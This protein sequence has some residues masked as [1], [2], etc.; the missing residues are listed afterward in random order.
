M[1]LLKYLSLSIL[2]LLFVV[3]AKATTSCDTHAAANS[4]ANYPTE[5]W[6]QNM[7][8][9]GDPNWYGC[10]YSTQWGLVEFII[11]H[12]QNIPGYTWDDV[13]ADTFTWLNSHSGG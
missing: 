5:Y 12:E 3:K 6:Y 4:L 11:S 13:R 8:Q 9:V 7:W 10:S 2:L 1:K